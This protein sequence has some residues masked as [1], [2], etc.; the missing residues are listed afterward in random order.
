MLQCL[1]LL[2][3]HTRRHANQLSCVLSKLQTRVLRRVAARCYGGLP[4]QNELVTTDALL[5]QPLFETLEVVNFVLN[6]WDNAGGEGPRDTLSAALPSL[7][8]R[9]LI[10]LEFESKES[11]CE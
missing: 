2:R 9:Q 5:S 10:L 8:A 11:S 1:T 3:W 4:S 6:S 7:A